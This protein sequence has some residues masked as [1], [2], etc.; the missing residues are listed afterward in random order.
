M[1]TLLDNPVY[2]ALTSGDNSLSHGENVAK[3][4]DE[5]VSPFAGFPMDYKSG[6]DDLYNELPPGR[7][8]LYATINEI[9][10][11]A[12]WQ[13]AAYIKGSQFVFDDMNYS[14]QPS[15]IPVPLTDEH[16]AEMVA[17]AALTKPGPFNLR[18]IDFGYY[19]GFFEEGKLVAMTG[20]RLHPGNYAE[21]SAVCTHPGHL[22][23]GYATALL[24]HQL[25]LICKQEKMPFLHVRSDNERAIGVYESL[26]FRLRGPMHFYFMKSRKTV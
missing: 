15:Q 23:K 18:T 26:G 24:Q 5:S 11:P 3:Y 25:L 16:T 9:D 7:R 10:I 4:F 20:Q 6:F 13:L 12:N 17:L 8:I 2:H 22:G 21:V 1:E 19:Y 14:V